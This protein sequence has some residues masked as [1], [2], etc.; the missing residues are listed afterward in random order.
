MG[1]FDKFEKHMENVVD[2]VFSRAFRSDLQPVELATGIKKAMDDQATALTRERTIVPNHFL[3]AISEHDFGKL[4][5]WGEAEL[6]EELV[7]TA[8][9]YAR[10]QRYTFLGPLEIS[11]QKSND[12]P[13]GKIT[14]S[15]SSRRGAVAPA[16]VPT[17]NAEDPIIEIGEERYVLTGPVT[18]IGRGSK[19]D[20][21]VDDPGVSRQ[22]LEIRVTPRGVIA[23]DLNTTNGSFV[24]GHRITAATLVDGNTITIGRTRIMYWASSEP[25]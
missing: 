23:R 3:I 19:C 11:F 21:T 10:E 25:A 2:N 9:D 17:R 4:A 6:V 8:E 15:G 24:E 12:L 22:H 1:A 16:T 20:I 13:I 14:V 7:R 5:E 18:I